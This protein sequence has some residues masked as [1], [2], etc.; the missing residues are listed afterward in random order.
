MRR[1]C[2]DQKIRAQLAHPSSGLCPCFRLGS[3]GWPLSLSDQE[4]RA[5]LPEGLSTCHPSPPAGERHER[6]AL[7]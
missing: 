4:I 6:A 5:P 3:I 2:P 1:P 7:Q